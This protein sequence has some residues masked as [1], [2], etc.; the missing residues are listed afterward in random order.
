MKFKE[1]FG[2][3]SETSFEDVELDT[4]NELFVD[5]Y[6][7]YISRDEFSDRCSN[8]VVEYFSKLL[9]YAKLGDRGNGYKLVR[10][11][12]ENNE[13][14]LG[15]SHGTP[16][17]RGLG[18]NKGKKLFDI[19]CKSKAVETGLVSDIF[20]ASIMLE[21]VG[22]DKISDLTVNIILAD[23]I[24]YTQ[25]QCILYNVPMD[26]VRLKRPV[27]I[28]EEEKWEFINNLNLPTHNGNPIIL[29]PKNFV[30]PYLVYTYGR[31]YKVEMIPHY[32]R[33]VMNDPS[34]GLVKIL[35]RGLVVPSRTKIRK[36]FPCLKENVINYIAEHP[37]DYKVYKNK[38]LNYVEEKDV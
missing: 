22:Y 8:R 12:K 25:E 1:K 24:K 11:L 13:I 38:E 27:W 5:P 15:Y 31:F 29:V 3:N 14:R 19:L 9:H 34:S 28:A 33:R 16:C 21:K 30:R 6:L 17:G 35:K 23:L 4:D 37:A 20:D 2:I 32:E 10:H 36:A 7:I 18:H 26:I